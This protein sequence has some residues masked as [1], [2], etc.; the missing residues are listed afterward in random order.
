MSN[1]KNDSPGG[2][3]GDQANAPSDA[4]DEILTDGNVPA[5]ADLST[6]HGTQNGTGKEGDEN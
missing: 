3:M 6:D 1:P 5:D 4:A 2:A